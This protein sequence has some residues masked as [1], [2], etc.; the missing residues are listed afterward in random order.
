MEV[1]IDNKSTE[2][3]CTTKAAAYIAFVEYCKIHRLPVRTKDALGKSMNK[4]EVEEG[5]AMVGE[6]RQRVWK[7]IRL[8]V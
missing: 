1:A 6:K 8:T 5:F 2:T 4:H 3:S 7:G